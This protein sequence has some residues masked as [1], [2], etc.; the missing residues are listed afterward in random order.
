MQHTHCKFKLFFFR[1]TRIDTIGKLLQLQLISKEDGQE[2]VVL[3]VIF[4]NWQWEKEGTQTSLP[5]GGHSH[6]DTCRVYSKTSK[7]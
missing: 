4:V 2:L 3:V 5:R 7:M 6:L 1:K